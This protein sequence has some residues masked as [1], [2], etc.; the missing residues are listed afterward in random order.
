MRHFLMHITKNQMNL[1]VMAHQPHSLDL[2]LFFSADSPCQTRKTL[3]H[4]AKV[5]P[6]MLIPKRSA[7]I[8]KKVQKLGRHNT[9][10]LNGILNIYTNEK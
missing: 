5:D 1:L 7:G 9:R 4:W 6:K 3:K 2:S 10:K 8:L